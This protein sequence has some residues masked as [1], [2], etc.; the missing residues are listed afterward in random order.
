[1]ALYRILTEN[2][3]QE[4]IAEIISQYFDGF[5]LIEATGYYKGKQEKSLVIE[6]DIGGTKYSA[7]AAA[8]S[9]I[10]DICTDIRNLNQQE[11]VLLQKFYD[12]VSVFVY[13]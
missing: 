10:A 5:T 9:K 12:C 2:K 6:I 1:M 4:K 11:C 8:R 3:N 7:R 13:E